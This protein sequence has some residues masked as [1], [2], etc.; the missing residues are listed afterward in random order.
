[1]IGYCKIDHPV[2]KK[3]DGVILKDSEGKQIISKFTHQNNCVNK[4]KKV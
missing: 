3:V 1:M 4:E 2:F